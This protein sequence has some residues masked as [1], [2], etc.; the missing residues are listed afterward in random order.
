MDTVVALPRYLSR[1]EPVYQV[2]GLPL[3][4]RH[5]KCSLSVPKAV[6]DQVTLLE[7]PQCYQ[8]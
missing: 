7:Q 5:G 1:G 6:A 4:D 2:A 8:I 3:S